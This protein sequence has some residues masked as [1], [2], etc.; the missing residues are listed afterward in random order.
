[1]WTNSLFS[2]LLTGSALALFAAAIIIRPKNENL[3][4]CIAAIVAFIAGI[5][6]FILKYIQYGHPERVLNI[7]ARPGSKLSL[8]LMFTTV[9]LLLIVFFI[10]RRAAI[11]N[12]AFTI[13]AL[14]LCTAGIYSTGAQYLMP[15]RVAWNTQL[16]PLLYIASALCAGFFLAAFI[17]AAL[18]N[19]PAKGLKYAIIS[20]AVTLA[21]IAAYALYLTKLSSPHYS[22][23]FERLICGDLRPAFLG[24]V[25]L[26]IVSG[27]TALIFRN[28]KGMPAAVASLACWVAVCA[29]AYCIRFAVY[30]MGTSVQ[31]FVF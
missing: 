12:T 28:K 21:L 11:R 10:I 25:T 4:A 8:E 30:G 3:S 13:L 23:S 15:S 22:R 19:T 6:G 18:G 9:S 20:C 31:M 14:V 1:M 17:N 27:V 16:V 26:Y 29:A 2:G 7:L 5:T 24:A